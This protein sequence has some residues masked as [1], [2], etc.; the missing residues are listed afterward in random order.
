MERWESLLEELRAEFLLREE[1]LELLHEID[2]RLIQSERPLGTTFEFIIRRT[3]D[4]LGSDHMHILL[5]RGRS[6]ET[7]HSTDTSD[8]GQRV[9]ITASLTGEALATET[10]VNV[11]DLTRSSY[12]SRYVPIQGYAGAPMRSLLAAPIKVHD[13]VIGVLN[14]ESTRVAYFKPVHEHIIGNI[15][16]Q[17]SIALQ[18][19]QLFDRNKLFAEV[20]QRIFGTGESQQVIPDILHRV[21]AALQELEHIP[22]SGAQILF[23]RGEAELEIVYS[24]H[25]TDV[26][27]VVGIDESICG[28]AVRN[29]DT[30]AIADVD[31]EPEYRRLLGSS[32][33]SEIAIPL[34]L[35]DST[36]VI[37]VLNVESEEPDAFEGFYRVILEAFADKVRTLLAFAK[38]RADVTDSMELRNANDLLVAVGDQA[39]NMIHRLNN[40]VGLMRLRILELQEMQEAGA[41]SEDFLTE[42]L[43]TLRNLAAKTLQMPEEVTRL[44][45]QQ[46]A[47][48]NVNEVVRAVLDDRFTMP[49]NVDLDL[50]LDPDM[51]SLSL[52]NFDIVV[53]NLVQNALDAMPDGG[54][55]S[56]STSSI[57][58]SKLTGYVAL[59]VRDTGT[60]IPAEILPKIFE[61]NFSTKH[62]K[63]RGLGLGLWWIRNFVLRAMGDISVT[64]SGDSGTEFI[65]KFPLEH[66]VRAE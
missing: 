42:T 24:T 26:G 15:A 19:S 33:Q 8:L 61:L 21:M 53:Q 23:R 57:L 5:R 65:V 60:G 66:A 3:L 27:L 49:D 12:A 16:A 48:V 34:M 28:R 7:V 50:D 52:Y 9:D 14:A 11:A 20:D 18:R 63:G 10:I 37:G 44:L 54:T 35:G 22:L 46:G 58:P 29:H 38:L 39:S 59:T 43:T 1:E 30:V 2:L 32:I 55:L 36:V 51:P 47:T 64:S 45:S 25:P 4:L 62:V 17:V 13:K 40:S 56:V 6:L 31:K 41:L